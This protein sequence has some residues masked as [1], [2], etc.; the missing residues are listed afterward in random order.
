MII[1]GNDIR[2]NNETRNRKER[3]IKQ[4]SKQGQRRKKMKS[5]SHI[6]NNRRRKS[7][8]ATTHQYYSERHTHKKG[9][10]AQ[11]GEM[12]ISQYVANCNNLAREEKK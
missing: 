6:G 5:S 8:T 9:E 2:V 7:T 10:H 12:L 11:Q 3:K 1:S 4:T